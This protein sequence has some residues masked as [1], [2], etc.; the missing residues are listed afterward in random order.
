MR[1][2]WAGS[3]PFELEEVYLISRKSGLLIAFASNDMLDIESE[4]DAQVIGSMLTAIKS[5]VE[6][7]FTPDEE[8][9]LEEI[10]YSNRTINIDTC[11]YSYLASVYSGVPG[12]A[13]KKEMQAHH[14]A[15]H[16]QYYRQLRDYEGDNSALLEVESNLQQFIRKVHSV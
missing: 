1:Q 4:N 13:F 12:P 3:L 9:E 5:F 6:D 2:F 7:A 8:G 11:R 10:E 15:V 16:Q 14:H